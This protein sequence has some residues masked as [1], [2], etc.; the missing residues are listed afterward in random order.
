MKFHLLSRERRVSGGTLCSGK[1]YLLSLARVY[2]MFE[3]L[4]P[5]NML[6]PRK[7]AAAGLKTTFDV[8]LVCVH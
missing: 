1:L 5:K 4:N 2:A 7:Y 6:S 3:V 8:T